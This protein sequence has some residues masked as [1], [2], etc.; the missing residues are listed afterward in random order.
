MYLDYAA[1]T[2]V[3]DEVK[4]VLV[5]SFDCFGNP[6]SQH[7]KGIEARIKINDASELIAQKI[8]CKPTEINYTSG[9][10][11]SNNVAI[12]GFFRRNPN[13]ILITSHLEHNDIILMCDWLASQEK[14]VRYVSNNRDGLI[15]TS[16]LN[17]M[18]EDIRTESSEPILVSIQSAN[19]ETGVFQQIGLIGGICHSYKDVFF[20]TDATQYLPYFEVNVKNMN[21]D[22]LSMSGQKIGC[23]KGTGLLYVK[24]GTPIS[25]IIFGE[26]RLIGGTENTLGIICLAE[27]FKHINYNTLNQTQV[28]NNMIENLDGILVGS[29]IYRLPNNIYMLFP[30]VRSELMVEILSQNNICSSGGSACSSISNEPSHVLIAMG[31]SET[32]AS[33]CVRFTLPKNMSLEE[34]EKICQTINN[35]YEFLKG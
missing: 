10:T 7:K 2:P 8:N 33:S 3:L 17:S 5:K 18:I 1:S 22:M 24:E 34:I 28:R 20:H 25:P 13:G 19:S 21:I 31:Y 12:Q 27:A 11:M 35:C 23:I 26:Q 32:E 16:I 9:A 4:D 14:N 29:N 15:D 6:S 30:G